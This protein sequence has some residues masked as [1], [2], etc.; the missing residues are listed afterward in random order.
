MRYNKIRKMDIANGPGIRVSIFM[1]GCTFNCKG[2][3][4][5]DTHSFTGGK[6]FNDG[7]I[8][9]IIRLASKE[10][11]KGLSI[12]GGEPL[13]KKNVDGTLKL[14]K[15]F[16]EKYPEKDI[17]VWSGFLYEDLVKNHNLKDIDVLVDGKYDQ[18]LYNPTLKYRGSA[19]QR[20]ID[21]KKSLKKNKIVLY[22]GVN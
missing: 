13:H 5:P 18:D 8:E 19:N 10:Y 11:I 6:E 12:L 7:E 22:E 17:W 16:K 21:I 15:I 3:F 14:A 20:V 9:K 4:N 1:Q 2:C